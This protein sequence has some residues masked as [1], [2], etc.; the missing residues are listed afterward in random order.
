MKKKLVLGIAASILALSL[1]VGGT[2]MLFTDESETASNT[3]TLGNVDIELQEYIGT[4]DDADV[5]ATLGRALPSSGDYTKGDDV[6]EL[7]TD[8]EGEDAVFSG[9]AFGDNVVPGA[10]L[11]KRPRVINAGLNDAYVKAEATLTITIPAET[12]AVLNEQGGYKTN[13]STDLTKIAAKL[14]SLALFNDGTGDSYSGPYWYGTV[15]EFT[16]GESP[17]SDGN[18]TATIEGTWYYAEK[19]DDT[20]TFAALKPRGETVDIFKGI[21][22]AK[23]IGNEFAGLGLEIEITAYAVQSDNNAPEAPGE[24]ETYTDV[25][26]KVFTYEA[27]DE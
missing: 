24:G 1:A 9:I 7:T 16:F 13:G 18:Y 27:P 6:G 17:D 8:G 25:W 3:V 15:P 11:E 14:Q 23:D 10:F 21:K 5:Y 20:P 4:K 22:L 2:L 26:E 19:E 12:L